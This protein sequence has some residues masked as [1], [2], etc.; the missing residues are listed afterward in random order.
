MKIILSPIKTGKHS[1]KTN[2][3]RYFDFY[4]FVDNSYFKFTSSWYLKIK[5][6]FKTKKSFVPFLAKI[7]QKMQ[8]DLN[9]KFPNMQIFSR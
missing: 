9:L 7:L 1:V 5:Q 6:I 3:S 2:L 4:F 8:F